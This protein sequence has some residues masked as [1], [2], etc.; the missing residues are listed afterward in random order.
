MG[1]DATLVSDEEIGLLQRAAGGDEHAVHELFW[2]H[3]ERHPTGMPQVGGPSLHHGMNLHDWLE[4]HILRREAER[5]IR[6]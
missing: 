3:R 2:R 5:L 1:G 4:G 6:R